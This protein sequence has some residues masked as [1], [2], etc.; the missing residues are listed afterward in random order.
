MIYK[1]SYGEDLTSELSRIIQIVCDSFD[2][3][4]TDISHSKKLNGYSTKLEVIGS[5]ARMTAMFFLGQKIKQDDVAKLMGCRVPSTV[6]A[7]KTRLNLMIETNPFV[8][9][10]IIEISNKLKNDKN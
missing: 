7:A 8:R 10:R 9:E 4:P 2:V 6:A 1:A 3:L 5:Y